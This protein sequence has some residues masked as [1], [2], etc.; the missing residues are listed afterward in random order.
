VKGFSP[1]GRF[2]VVQSCPSDGPSST[3]LHR[4]L[5]VC[6]VQAISGHTNFISGPS[7]KQGQASNVHLQPMM[8][9]A[10]SL[11]GR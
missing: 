10:L 1:S 4:M 11:L 7:G 3:H 6:N 9:L 2:A 8:S 5:T